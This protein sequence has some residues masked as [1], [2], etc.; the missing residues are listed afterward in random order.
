[1]F[2]MKKL[3]LLLFLVI[4]FANSIHAEVEE[5]TYIEP[6]N[7]FDVHVKQITTFYSTPG[8]YLPSLTYSEIFYS[9]QENLQIHDNGKNKL[10]KVLVEEGEGYQIY[11]I[12]I[13]QVGDTYTNYYSTTGDYFY[14]YYEYDLKDTIAIYKE[15]FDLDFVFP[16]NIE[17]YTKRIHLCLPSDYGEP[18]SY[19]SSYQIE[20][21]N[22]YDFK[23][24][25]IRAITP[26]NLTRIV[27][28]DTFTPPEPEPNFC[29]SGKQKTVYEREY[30]EDFSRVH[31]RWSSQKNNNGLTS[32]TENKIV[33]NIPKAYESRIDKFRGT[34]KI[35]QYFENQGFNTADITINFADIKDDI[36]PSEDIALVCYEDGNC[37]ITVS[38]LRDRDI[39]SIEF[40]RTILLALQ[41]NTYGKD[42][43]EKTS[44][45]WEIGSSSL[46]SLNAIKDSG[47]DTK[48]ID[49]MMSF[50]YYKTYGDMF[51][52]DIPESDKGIV[53]MRIVMDIEDKCP[54]HI[55]E[56][57]DLMDKTSFFSKSNTVE[58]VNT[59]VISSYSRYC[60]QSNIKNVFDKYGLQ[61]NS[62]QVE[63]YINLEKKVDSN[64]RIFKYGFWIIVA[65]VLI[66]IIVVSTDRFSFWKKGRDVKVKI[67]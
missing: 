34:E 53:A 60:D 48:I 18:I 67:K 6:T 62:D 4:I 23:I 57:F 52:K 24:P 64:Q 45:W 31:E 49:E 1:M 58:E 16:S 2:F 51:Y 14:V 46:L 21:Y 3:I 61:Y 26:P 20:D 37:F 65:I 13:P 47:K 33:V 55:K 35:L 17:D 44:D 39:D 66:I 28:Y 40:V 32:F 9:G 5:N 43:T 54:G 41:V 30:D 27:P 8:Y 11:N 56:T 25:T 38:V 42:F 22:T 15:N 7:T 63:Y 19:D 36:F 12:T 29:S 10:K 50:D 59:I